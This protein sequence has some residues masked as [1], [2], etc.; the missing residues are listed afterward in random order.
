M[1]IEAQISKINRSLEQ[2]LQDV[3]SGLAPDMKEL[4]DDIN[5]FIELAHGMPEPQL[6]E[7]SQLLQVWAVEIK[8]MSDK[9]GDTKKTLEGEISRSQQQGKATMAYANSN[10]LNKKPQE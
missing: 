3:F 4:E 1:T 7:Y 2:K 10:A 6:R 8:K 9:L 5:H